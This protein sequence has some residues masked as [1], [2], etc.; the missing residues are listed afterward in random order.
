MIYLCPD[1]KTWMAFL[2]S[3]AESVRLFHL[4]FQR[5]PIGIEA[6]FISHY[7]LTDYTPLYDFWGLLYSCKQHQVALT[8]SPW[9]RA[10]PG[11]E[12]LCLSTIPISLSNPLQ[13]VCA[14]TRWEPWVE[15]LDRQGNAFKEFIIS[16]QRNKGPCRHSTQKLRQAP[17]A[18]QGKDVST[19]FSF[20]FVFWAW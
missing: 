14:K 10:M 16:A 20:L 6:L 12:R 8:C 9:E 4:C 5:L 15:G 3:W 7:P 19:A 17:V 1:V 2:S 11:L 13:W 18:L